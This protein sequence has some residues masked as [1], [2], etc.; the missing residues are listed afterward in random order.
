[1]WK[2][3]LSDPI[4]PLNSIILV[5][6][7]NGLIASNVIDQLLAAGYRV[8]GTVRNVKDNSWLISLLTEKHGAGR[9]E[10]IEVK[11]ICSPGC[12]NEAVRGVS[13]IAHV[14][15][16]VSLNAPEV[17]QF[18]EAELPAHISLLEAARAEESIK[19]FVFTSSAFAVWTPDARESVTLS[20]WDWNE[21][22]VE[23]ARSEAPPQIK[24]L[25]PWMA[26][27]TLLEKRI[28]EWVGSQ[29]LPFNFNSI[30]LDTVIGYCLHPR[31]KGIPSTTG[32]VKWVFDGSNR[33][34]LDMMQPQ[35]FI[36]CRDAALL[37]LAVLTTQGVNRERIFGFGGRYSWPEVNRILR[38]LYPK[39][40]IPVMEDNGW[41]QTT[42]PNKRSG[43]LLRRVKLAGWTTL[44]RSVAASAECFVKERYFE[45]SIL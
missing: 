40:D 2:P 36:D 28:W 4:I 34:L 23:L 31:S 6:G 13:G 37:Y 8:R 7:A 17:D 35:W 9:L 30:V 21:K 41:D 14:I 3:H 39:K 16:A 32:M 19:S 10:I 15:G 24:G 22:A 25:A 33:Y 27:K 11:D 45:K 43:D 42:V 1:M 12:W 5:T 38:E 29:E 20:E 26:L 18:L 44:E